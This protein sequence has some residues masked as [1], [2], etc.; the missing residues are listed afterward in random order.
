[1]ME[2]NSIFPTINDIPEKFKLDFPIKQSTYLL[3]GEIE[4]WENTGK[5]THLFLLTT[6][7]NSKT[8]LAHIL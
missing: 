2:L 6:I 4:Q 8:I 5:F 3:D 1:M 7:A